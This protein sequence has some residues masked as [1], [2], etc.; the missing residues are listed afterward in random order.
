MC[1]VGLGGRDDFADVRQLPDGSADV[2]VMISYGTGFVPGVPL[3]NLE[4]G[5]A[6]F[7]G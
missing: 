3:T 4:F 6:L 1:A 2:A 5:S 7:G